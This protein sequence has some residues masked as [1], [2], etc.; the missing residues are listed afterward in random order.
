[1]QTAV[2]VVSIDLRVKEKTAL[3]FLQY[4]TFIV[5]ILISS[6]SLW[7]FLERGAVMVDQDHFSSS[8]EVDIRFI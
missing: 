2:D 1:M 3:S 8:K 4:L 7:L 6:L 5:A